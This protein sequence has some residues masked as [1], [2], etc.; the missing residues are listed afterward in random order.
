MNEISEIG[1][2]MSIFVGGL[3]Y[4]CAWCWAMEHQ[5]NCNRNAYWEV[6]VANIFILLHIIAMIVWF[7]WSWIN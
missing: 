7:I 6:I 3:L 1:K 4:L 5:R 2:T